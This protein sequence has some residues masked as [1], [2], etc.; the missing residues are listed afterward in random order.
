MAI[1][2]AAAAGP[3]AI[4]IAL[5][6]V[7]R[8]GAK[9]FRVYRIDGSFDDL[10]GCCSLGW[11]LRRRDSALLTPINRTCQLQSCGTGQQG[12]YQR[13]WIDYG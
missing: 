7:A 6:T 3:A 10:Q 9:Y 5:T 4:A 12:C 1:T 11:R 13:V 8:N 2:A